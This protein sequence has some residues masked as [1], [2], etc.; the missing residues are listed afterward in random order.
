[1]QGL[2][3][4]MTLS[5]WQALGSWG[6][7]VVDWNLD[8]ADFRHAGAGNA[9]DQNWSPYAQSLAGSSPATSSFISLQVPFANAF[10][11]IGTNLYF[12]A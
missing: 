2:G 7:K 4:N 1:M 5:F 3:W 11:D 8:S 9:M 12:V 10:N 6:Y